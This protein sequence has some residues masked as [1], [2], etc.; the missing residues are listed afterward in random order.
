MNTEIPDDATAL[1][2]SNALDDYAIQAIEYVAVTV[3]IKHEYN[4]DIAI[5]LVSPSGAISHLARPRR[6]ETNDRSVDHSGIF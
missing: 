6:C 1:T 2:T 5:D 4:G 3:N